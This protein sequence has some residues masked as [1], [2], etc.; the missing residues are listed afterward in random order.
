MAQ[1]NTK[2]IQN[3]IKQPGSFSRKAQKRGMT[4]NEL[5]KNVIANP[6]RYDKTTVKQANLA[7]TLNRLRPTKKRKK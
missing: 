1:K 3:A 4:T 6:E 5:A 7:L 2:W